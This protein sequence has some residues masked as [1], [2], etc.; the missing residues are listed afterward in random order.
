M[1]VTNKYINKKP[2]VYL[3]KDNFMEERVTQSY[4]HSK[5]N[6]IQSIISNGGSLNPQV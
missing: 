5:K 2:E 6:S 1:Y 4:G 3:R